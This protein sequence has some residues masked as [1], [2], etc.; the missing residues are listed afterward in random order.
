MVSLDE[1]A[2]A[3]GTM[4]G[5]LRKPIVVMGERGPSNPTPDGETDEYWLKDYWFYPPMFDVEFVGENKKWDDHFVEGE[6][7]ALKRHL[8]LLSINNTQTINVDPFSVYVCIENLQ[9]YYKKK[10]KEIEDL[11]QK[12]VITNGTQ[13]ST[14]ETP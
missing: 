12:T 2:T 5:P 8:L 3:K 7:G 9:R 6:M 11:W 10:I 14:T 1:A 4:S 13:E